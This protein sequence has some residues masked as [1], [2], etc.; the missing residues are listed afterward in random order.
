VARAFLSIPKSDPSLAVLG[1]WFIDVC[2][3]STPTPR[4][5]CRGD[6]E[7]QYNRLRALYLFGS[8]I[9]PLRSYA[10]AWLVLSFWGYLCQCSYLLNQSPRF[11]SDTR[12]L[13]CL[14]YP[15]LDLLS[16]SISVTIWILTRIQLVISSDLSSSGS[17]LVAFSTCYTPLSVARFARARVTP[18]M[19]EDK[20][21]V[22]S[23]TIEHTPSL[24]FPDGRLYC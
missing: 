3:M 19:P 5:G 24:V 12:V 17:R 11:S 10:L 6:P 8:L 23:V 16:P 14:I 2:T 20:S 4:L 21:N 1:L 22:L 9:Y 18:F 15:E 13:C 7:F